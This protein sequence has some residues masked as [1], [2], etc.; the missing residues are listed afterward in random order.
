[1]KT[2]I[3]EWNPQES[4]FGLEDFS[5]AISSMEFG[6]L[7]WMFRRR[8]GIRS[9]DNF[10][11]VKVGDGLEGIVMKGFFRTQP[12]AYSG[13]ADGGFRTLLRPTFMVDVRR[14][15]NIISK[16]MLR[17]SL[18]TLPWGDGVFLMNPRECDI[19][20]GLWEEYLSGIPQEAFSEGAL[21]RRE[22]PEAIFDDAVLIAAE[23]LYEKRDRDGEPAILHAIEL[24]SLWKKENNRI[25]SLLFYA[26]RFSDLDA[27]YVREKGFSEGVADIVCALLC[28]PG[29]SMKE[30]VNSI[31]L[32]DC[33]M[34]SRIIIRDMEQH[35]RNW[36]ASCLEN[37]PLLRRLHKSA[38][39]E[40]EC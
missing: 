25:A 14:N 12:E 2:F 35:P 30:Y 36:D 37:I 4:S 10:Y 5:H 9:G 11:L 13:D 19:L 20:S 24:S 21:G 7:P 28:K 40:L 27:G 39:W 38:G 15:A 17:A 22:R 18:P 16:E 3:I 23:T 1:M 31:I 32:S 33:P 34:A 29:A 26:S 8:C 6:D